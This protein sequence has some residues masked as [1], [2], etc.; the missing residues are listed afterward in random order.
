MALGL[1]ASFGLMPTPSLKIEV[2]GP[3]AIVTL[4]RPD[5]RNALSLE[6]MRDLICELARIESSQAIQTVIL[7]AAGPVFCSGHDLCEMTG[8]TESEYRALFDTCTQLMVKLQSMR[9]PVI[10]E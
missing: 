4:N 9:Q 8:R 3:V 1:M 7:S 2:N 6:L 10:A 5:R